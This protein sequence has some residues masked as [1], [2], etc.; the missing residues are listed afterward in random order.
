[1]LYVSINRRC[2]WFDLDEVELE[3]PDA[4]CFFSRPRIPVNL[5]EGIDP[6]LVLLV[7]KLFYRQWAQWVSIGNPVQPEYG[8]PR[9]PSH[10]LE[11]GVNAWDIPYLNR[12]KATAILLRRI[13]TVYG[14]L[15][16]SFAGVTRYD[17]PA[18]AD[19]EK[20]LDDQH[21]RQNASRP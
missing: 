12:L 7:R 17:G 5:A 2:L 18:E 16:G 15:K 9:V 6:Q 11:L 20:F 14:V 3:V 10:H 19:I 1:M 21:A 4:R 13:D 8:H